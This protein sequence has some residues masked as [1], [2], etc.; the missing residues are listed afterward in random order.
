MIDIHTHILPG[1][2][3]G[4]ASMEEAVAMAELA[5]D[6]GIRGIVATSHGNLGGYTLEDYEEA[7]YSLRRA[8]EKERI[9][10]TLYTGMEIFMNH[11]ALELLNQK[12]LL[13]LN[14]TSYVLVEFD[15]QEE[16]WMVNDYLQ[17]LQEEGYIPVIAHV[18][19]YDFVQRH[20][21]EV[22]RWANQG[23]VLQGNKGSFLGAFGREVK[24]T[25]LSLLR[26]RLIHVIASDAHGI[27]GRT[28]SMGNIYR[29]LTENVPMQYRDVLLE[30]NP[31]RILRGKEILSPPPVP[32]RRKRIW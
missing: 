13:T 17:S 22:Y 2:D 11:E 31:E 1:L 3:D 19:R 26:H 12:E 32:Y 7:F 18:E 14:R 23:Y 30:E 8:L 5:I 10:I 25:A 9:P 16:L 15:F 4:A 20:L 21:D 6:S 27:E 24:E 29:F 28:P